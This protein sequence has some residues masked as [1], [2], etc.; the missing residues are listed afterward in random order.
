[1]VDLN[2]REVDTAYDVFE[3][4]NKIMGSSVLPKRGVMRQGVKQGNY[5]MLDAFSIM[6]MENHVRG[7]ADKIAEQY[8]FDPN[9]V[10]G[11]SK[12]WLSK[13]AEP[14]PIPRDP[15]IGMFVRYAQEAEYLDR[16]DRALKMNGGALPQAAEIADREE[17]LSPPLEAEDRRAQGPLRVS[18]D[19][20]NNM[21]VRHL[22]RGSVRAR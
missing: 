14:S 4:V 16:L 1:M 13:N 9:E 12:S 2:D 17:N 15:R 20:R 18:V 22:F 5:G 11:Y 10:S 6:G 3:R 7:R 19:P 21:S 8:E